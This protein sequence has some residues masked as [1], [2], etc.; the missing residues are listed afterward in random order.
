MV[1]ESAPLARVRHST[2][3]HVIDHLLFILHLSSIYALLAHPLDSKTL[4]YMLTTPTNGH[5]SS[6]LDT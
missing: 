5:S 6:H 2:V 4:R 3:N 1:K